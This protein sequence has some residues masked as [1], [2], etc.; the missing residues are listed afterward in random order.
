MSSMFSLYVSRATSNNLLQFALT[1]YSLALFRGLTFAR[2]VK[3]GFVVEGFWTLSRLP[4]ND[5]LPPMSWS[6]ISSFVLASV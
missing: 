3:T 1:A 6:M 4:A 5:D 2:A